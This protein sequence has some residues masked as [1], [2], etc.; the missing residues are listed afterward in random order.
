MFIF[1]AG[2]IRM[3]FKILA[4]ILGVVAVM[5][6]LAT[7]SAQA[8]EVDDTRAAAE[9]GDA[10]GQSNLGFM[11]EFGLGVPQDYAEAVT[12]YRLAAEQ[13]HATGQTSLGFMYYFGQG[14]PQDYAEA[15]KW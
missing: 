7:A 13:G 5:A 11:Y 14:V 6:C 2:Q 1:R 9:Q 10:R 4:R 15:V 12:W 3:I 8:G